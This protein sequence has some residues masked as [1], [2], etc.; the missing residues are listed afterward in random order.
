M[1]VKITHIP[2]NT[3]LG[4]FS[5]HSM[6]TALDEMAQ[7]KKYL[8]FEEF[9]SKQGFLLNQIEN[10]RKEFSIIKVNIR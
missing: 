8:S 7:Q 9:A 10:H 4:I 2:S 6:L 3:N 5:V 1:I